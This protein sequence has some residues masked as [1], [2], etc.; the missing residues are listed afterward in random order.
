MLNGNKFLLWRGFYLFIQDTFSRITTQNCRKP[1]CIATLYPITV[2]S[3]VTNWTISV[4]RGATVAITPHWLS[5]REF[6]C[7]IF[8]ENSRSKADYSSPNA[9][10]TC[11]IFMAGSTPSST[12][13]DWER[14]SSFRMRVCARFEARSCGWEPPGW[15]SFTWVR[16]RRIFIRMLK[17]SCWAGRGTWGSGT[18]DRRSR[19]RRISFLDAQG[20]FPLFR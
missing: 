17:R 10:P 14:E 4:A 1:K 12:A 6:T 19:W 3:P 7:D 20:W 9:S 15:K 8:G 18:R 16:I 13:A 5:N 2:D 11:G